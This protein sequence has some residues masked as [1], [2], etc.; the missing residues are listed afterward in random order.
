MRIGIGMGERK[1]DG[2]HLKTPVHFL[3][4]SRAILNALIFWPV[5][6]F[7]QAKS[8]LKCIIKNQ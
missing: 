7:A 2:I 6:T 3:V 5:G 1:I 8:L 4:K